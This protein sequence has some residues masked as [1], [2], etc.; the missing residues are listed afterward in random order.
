MAAGLT[1][2]D[3][4]EFALIARI[5]EVVAA[6][7]AL[8]GDVGIGDDA[9]VI[10][11]GRDPR[12]V[13]T[14]DVLVEGRHFRLDW[15]AAYDIGRKAA[16][17]S[18]ADIEAMGARP[19][20]LLVGFAAPGTTSLDF[21]MDV[22]RGLADE[23]AAAGARV[24]GGDTVSADRITISVAALGSLD[25]RRPMLRSGAR[26]GD[27]VYAAGLLGWS[28]A[29]LALLKRGDVDLI[30]RHA[31]L[32]A[33]HRV[34][35]PPYGYGQAVTVAGCT[36]MIDVSDGLLADLGHLVDASGVGAEL[37]S[38]SWQDEALAA[39]ASD[40]GVDPDEWCTTGGEDH[41]LLY[42]MPAGR[43]APAGPQV[44]RLGSMVAAPGISVDGI[45][46][47][48]GGFDHFSPHGEPGTT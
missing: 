13:A 15:S 30:A 46:I 7:P 38:G 1:L 41:A 47:A 26:V 4:G 19:V 48:R 2:A 25:G 27:E 22:A 8:V 35:R 36:S 39:A 45:E 20:A 11:L 40:L 16:A 21:A 5:A 42:T 23:A 17:Q 32:V 44:R 43:S 14:T 9:A 3:I 28:A 33:T 6:Q 29:G 31:D 34:P 24:S 10:R 12:V 37:S 18:L